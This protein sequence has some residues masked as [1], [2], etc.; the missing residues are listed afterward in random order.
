MKTYMIKRIEN[1]F[2]PGSPIKISDYIKQLVETEARCG[3]D[4]MMWAE[5]DEYILEGYVSYESPETPQ[6]VERRVKATKKRRDEAKKPKIQREA[7]ERALY[8]KLKVKFENSPR[9]T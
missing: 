4:A 3:S 6:E 8:D 5:H 2:I 1:V 9:K 7:S